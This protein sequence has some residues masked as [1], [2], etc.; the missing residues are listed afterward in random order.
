MNEKRNAMVEQA[1]AAPMACLLCGVRVMP[2]DLAKHRKESCEGRAEPHQYD[3]WMPEMEIVN[4]K[5]I[6]LSLLRRLGKSDAI[7]KR[8]GPESKDEYL[9]RD[10]EHFLDSRDLFE[11]E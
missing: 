2:K 5:G 11:V 3:T 1:H 4:T 8:P 9:L 7:R 6:G 10:V